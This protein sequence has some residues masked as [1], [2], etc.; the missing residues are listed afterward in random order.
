M[1]LF[2]VDTLLLIHPTRYPPRLFSP[3]KPKRY[4][5]EKYFPYDC[6]KLNNLL[7]TEQGLRLIDTNA[8]MP[9]P[10]DGRR[11]KSTL[12]EGSLKILELIESKL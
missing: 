12:F 4:D 1:L 9:I 10:E 3:H 6:A 7:F 11:W 8:V 5:K 2:L